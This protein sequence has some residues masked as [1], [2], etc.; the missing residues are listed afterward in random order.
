M[1]SEEYSVGLRAQILALVMI[2]K[3]KPQDVA[4][5]PNILQN[6]V[7]RLQKQGPPQISHNQID[8]WLDLPELLL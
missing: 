6:S 3:L 2:V 7:Y 4:K 8:P 5:M 1:T